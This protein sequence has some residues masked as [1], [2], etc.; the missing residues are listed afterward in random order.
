MS[1]PSLSLACVLLLPATAAATDVAPTVRVSIHDAPIDGTGDSFNASPFEGLIRKVAPTQEDRAIQEFDVAPFTTQP[2]V[3]ATLSGTVFVNNAFDNGVRTFAFRLYAGDGLGTL[4]DYQ[5]PATQVG[6]G[7]Y[8]PPAQSSFTYSF[9][10]TSAVQSLI[11]GGATWIGLRVE[12]TSSPN[13]PNV[14]DGAT[15]KL[16]VVVS[17]TTGVPFCFGDGSATACPCGNASAP[18]A[19]L[20]CLNSLGLG[21][22][23]SA[24][25]IASVTA[26]SLV[27]QGSNMPSA[28]ALYFQG[29]TPQNGGAGNVF[30]DGLRCVGGTVIRLGTKTNVGGASQYPGAG[31]PSVSV[32]GLIPA[33]GG[34]YHYQV[35]YR[36]AA[37]FC[38]PSTFNLTNGLTV[39]WST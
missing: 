10:V 38:T 5:V 11:S 22:R 36:N 30:G 7:S 21:G 33:G 12:A 35:W 2:L 18:G 17:P 39:L 14:L 29:S 6:T 1:R 23:V 37:D 26:D 15:S 25:G 34:A 20:G 32:R 3:S 8:H 4:G 19:N 9:D 31:D 28:P 27:L 24:T 13:F 16:A